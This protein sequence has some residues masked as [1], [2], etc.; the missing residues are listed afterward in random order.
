MKLCVAQTRPVRGAVSE[1]IEKHQRFI[2]RAVSLQADV[3]IF[4]E[5]SITGY[6]PTLAN[7]LATTPD[8]ERFAVFQ[9]L[10][11]AH[12]LTIGIGVPTR[13]EAGI[14]ITMVLFTA[15]QPSQLYSKKYLHADEKPFFISGQNASVLLRNQPTV[16]LAICYELSVPEH[17]LNAHQLGASIYLVSVAKTASG[18]EKAAQTLANIASNYSMTVLMANSVG[19][20]DDFVSGGKSAIWSTQGA[21]LGELNG[22]KEGLLLL[23]TE[24]QQV[25]TQSL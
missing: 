8:D 17:A 9:Q 23:D 6:E 2:K 11:D 19:P 4:P 25:I 21:L 12:N 18:V 22:T 3:I 10:S 7:E 5:L 15:N 20:S 13:N 24:T 1:N 14:C 16:A